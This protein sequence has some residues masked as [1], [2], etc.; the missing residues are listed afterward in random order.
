MKRFMPGGNRILLALLVVGLTCGCGKTTETVETS[1][2]APTS[3]A[4]EAKAASAPPA[5]TAGTA[6][7]P[8]STGVPEAAPENPFNNPAAIRTLAPEP[9]GP[10]QPGEFVLP[11]VSEPSPAGPVMPEPPAESPAP[12]D[13]APAAPASAAPA[14]SPSPR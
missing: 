14:P 2:P 6:A 5:T 9:P 12:A 11:S 4:S 13:A 8:S 7:T 1:S 3:P 10:H